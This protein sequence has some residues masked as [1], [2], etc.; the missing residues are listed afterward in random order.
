MQLEWIFLRAF[1]LRVREVGG[2]GR[3]GGEKERHRGEEGR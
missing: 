3:R 2:R 1:S